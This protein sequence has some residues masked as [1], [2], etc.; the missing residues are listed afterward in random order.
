MFV[1]IKP[2]GKNQY[3]QIVENYQTLEEK[4]FQ[5]RKDLFSSL[6]LVFFD[7]TSI[8]F[9]GEGGGLGE[10]GYSKD[11]RPDLNAKRI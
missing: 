3:L 6:K 10:Y 11:H 1:R 8:Y 4:L 5:C 7:T 9:E 2:S